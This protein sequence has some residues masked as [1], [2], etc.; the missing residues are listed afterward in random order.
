MFF[1]PQGGQ[2]NLAYLPHFVPFLLQRV[3]QT[4]RNA[5]TDRE[6][7]V[8][9]EQT[10]STA[11][12]ALEINE[13]SNKFGTFAEIGAGQEV[14]RWFFHVGRASG[15][16]AKSIS[17]YDMAVS[18]FLYGATDRYVSRSR[19]EAMLTTEFAQLQ[20]RHSDRASEP[21][22][23]FVFA[24]TVT[25][26]SLAHHRRGQGWMGIRFQNQPGEETS[27]IIIHAEMLDGETVQEQ[28]AIGVLGVN[29]IYAAFYSNHDP[30]LVVHSLTDG[31]N[32][33]RVDVDMIKFS[34]PAF[35][36]IDNRLMSLQLVESQL[37]DA[38][39]FTAQG[40]VVQASEVL[41]GKPVLIERGS[42]RPITN[43][44]LDMLVQA[45]KQIDAQLPPQGQP[46]VVV[47]EMTLNNLITEQKIDHQDFLA[48]VDL[49]GALGMTVMV[50][51]HTR[52][53]GV[54][55]Y[56][57]KSTPNWI[58]MVMGVPTLRE[59]FD[60]KY[61]TDLPGGILEG[62]GKLFQGNVKLFIYPT[63]ETA[64]AEVDTADLLD[65]LPRQRGLYK[66][67]LERGSMEAIREFDA[68]QLHITPRDV[69]TRLQSGDPSWQTMVPPEVAR[70]IRERRLFEESKNPARC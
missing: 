20:N 10:R 9:M 65:V 7:M 29:L 55:S 56:L 13:D 23:L 12:K 14:A 21:H 48:R 50:S 45:K 31:L 53:D 40:D 41:Y 54:T 64:A 28:A 39:L 44:T 38:A 52:F 24:D 70:L 61:Y 33:R 69:L 4:D 27:D 8:E 36:G 66:Y 35:A 1:I 30:T 58:G 68:A 26:Q 25:T 16:V 22:A 11:Q 67:L 18:D 6:R 51:N 62:F 57:R 15:T 63:R 3:L 5:L 34:G 59:L 49:L 46:P 32:R 37:T 43:V 42:F 2:V 19:L 47:M 60:E 17:A